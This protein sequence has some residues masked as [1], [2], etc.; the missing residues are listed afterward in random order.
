MNSLDDLRIFAIVARERSFTKAAALL[1]MPQSSVSRTVRLL[2]ERL[3]TRLL[4]RT[5]RSVS[6]T[7]AGELLLRGVGP[8]IE[9]IDAELLEFAGRAGKP[10]G[11]L[12]L[13]MVR[14]AYET[15]LR[16]VLPSFLADNP[17]V[18]VEVAIDDGLSDIVAERFDAGIRFGGLVEK[19]MIALRVGADFRAAV[20]AAPSYVAAHGMPR[21]PDELTSHRCINYRMASSGELYRWWFQKDGEAVRARVEGSLVLN[22]GEAIVEA[23]LDGLGIG[24]MFRDRVERHIA[25]GSLVSLLEDWCP[26]F[27]GYHLY[28]PSRRHT[29]AA[30]KALV[31][32]LR[33]RR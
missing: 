20:V 18:A 5:T 27:P 17:R 32:S 3:D 31:A 29:P 8:A 30:L 12:R 25:D 19:D 23:A 33:G 6:P 28:Y 9:A 15:V 21:A 10:A 26:L 24:Y 7:E 13:T 11:I 22:D 1:G 14:H 4:A 16:P 2:E